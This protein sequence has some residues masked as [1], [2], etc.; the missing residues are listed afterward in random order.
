M[1]LQAHRIGAVSYV[2]WG[3]LHLVLG[4]VLVFGITSTGGTTALAVFGSGVPA[5]EWPQNLGGVTGGILAHYAWNLA[6]IGFVV[7]AVAAT[8]NWTNSR[9]G[10]WLNLGLVT[11]VELGFLVEI[12]LPGY[13]RLGPGLLAPILWAVA[14]VFSTIG[15]LTKPDASRPT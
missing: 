14:V 12:L 8:L 3:L 7:A 9:L 6:V 15:Y 2:L 1:R 10:Y 5:E 11:G 4:I 13:M